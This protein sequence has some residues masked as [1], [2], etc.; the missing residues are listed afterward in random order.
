MGQRLE[1]AKAR[2]NRVQ[3]FCDLLSGVVLLATILYLVFSWAEIPDTVPTHFNFSGEAD[4]WGS[5]NSILLCPILAGVFYIG[6]SAVILFPGA[7]NFPVKLTDENREQMFILGQEMLSASKA[8]SVLLLC[9]IAF[10]TASRQALSGL[11]MIIF[12]IVMFGVI[13]FYLVRMT[14]NK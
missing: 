9:Y 13:I 6:L 10:A 5:K 7:W 4:A 3:L 11:L 12:L 1:E 8:S 2:Y 14:H